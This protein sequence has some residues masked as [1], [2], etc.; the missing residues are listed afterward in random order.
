MAAMPRATASGDGNGHRG[1][2][3]CAAPIQDLLHLGHDLRL[4]GGHVA[5]QL[6]STELSPT[7]DVVVL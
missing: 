3:H 5:R 4:R 6:S 7:S 1:V 2:L